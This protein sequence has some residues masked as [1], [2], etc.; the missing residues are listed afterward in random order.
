MPSPAPQTAAA[1]VPAAGGS[2]PNSAHGGT[3]WNFLAD[4]GTP[5]GTDTLHAM[6]SPG[7]VVMN[8]HAA[9]TFGVQLTA[10][11]ANVKPSY[12]SHGGSVT[13]VGDI[14]GQCPRRR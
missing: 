4:G 2:M 3:A 11:N 13:N 7:E 1:T 14:N 12:H 9:R 10:M 8:A 6:L 5:R